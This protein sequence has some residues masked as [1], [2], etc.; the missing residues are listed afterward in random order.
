MFAELQCSLSELVC[1][2]ELLSVLLKVRA[3]VHGCW[4][5]LYICFDKVIWCMEPNRIYILQ[6]H[7]SGLQTNIIDF[8][9]FELFAKVE[10]LIWRDMSKL[11]IY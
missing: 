8:I 9:Y 2:V 11:F 3:R 6:I 1:T 4:R 10:I 7:G 5:I